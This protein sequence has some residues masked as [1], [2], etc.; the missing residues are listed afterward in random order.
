[1]SAHPGFRLL[2]ATLCAAAALVSSPLALDRSGE[3]EI[4]IQLGDLLS[5]EARFEEAADAY[6]R[7]RDASTGETRARA[8]RALVMALLRTPEFR[9]A[10]D[11]AEI[12]LADLPNDSEALALHGD[13]LWA[14][15]LFEE[16]EARYRQAANLDPRSARAHNGLAKGLAAQSRLASALE[17]VTT[18]VGL[19]PAHAEYH[20]TLGFICERLCRYEDAAAAFSDYVTLLR[21]TDRS[22]RT[23]W[24]R[25]QIRFLRSFHG[26]RPLSMR[27]EVEQA[28]HT[29]PFRLLRDKVVVRGSINGSRRFDLVLDTG[30]ELAAVTKR[31]A[32]HLGIDPIV[33]TLSAGVG[34][35]GMRGLQVGRLDSLQIGS[36]K[37]EN[38]PVLIKNP[39]LRDLPTEEAN[40][41]SPLAFGLSLSLDYGRRLLTMARALPAAPAETVLPLRLHRLALVRGIVN[42]DSP[43]HF[44]V[45]TGGEVISIS[46][47]TF[48][49]IK[50]EPARRIPLRVYGTS[51]W[52]PDAFLMPGLDL[53]FAQVRLPKFAVVVLNLEAPSA[54]LGFEVGGIVG[55]RFLS[56]YRVQ[57]DLE[58][59][60]LRLSAL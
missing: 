56:Q 12:L 53:A 15:G 28:V 27:Q 41:F 59:S 37:V 58:A 4:Q 3:P 55:H 30:S 47:A 52:D 31:T 34:Q 49:T 5:R 19:A 14:G 13:T 32:E 48:D 42:N 40:S 18:A 8:G 22:D 17:E 21:E 25:Q 43:V 11:E 7:A 57:I 2:F 38:V 45:D 16:A 10:R 9:R 20:H 50:R 60:Q 44:V 23:V 1:M 51:G 36:L 39:P 46:R 29:V 54:L 35:M 24:T 33:Y 26:R 6:R